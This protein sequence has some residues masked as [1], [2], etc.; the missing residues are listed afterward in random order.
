MDERHPPDH[1][2]KTDKPC[3]IDNCKN[4]AYEH[5]PYLYGLGWDNYKDFHN[6]E[7]SNPMVACIKHFEEV[8]AGEN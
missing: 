3:F 4:Q 1:H 8:W 5:I 2:R 6:G 7:Y